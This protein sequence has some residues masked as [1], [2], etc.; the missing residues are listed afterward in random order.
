MK[1]FFR[2]RGGGGGGRGA[3]KVIKFFA[4]ITEQSLVS[5]K[6]FSEKI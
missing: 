1:L 2:Q 4:R 6:K 5:Y 3:T